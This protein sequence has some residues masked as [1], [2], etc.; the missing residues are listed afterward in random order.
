MFTAYEV[1]GC[2]MS[3]KVNFL[4]SHID[5][6]PENLEAF[7]EEEG[8][9]FHKDAPDIERRYQGKWDVNML[10][11]YCWNAETGNRRWKAKA[12][13]EES[14]REI[15]KVSQTKRVNTQR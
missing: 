13:S 6:F 5:C 1:Q 15:E 12:C 11:D 8:E 3:L 9:I 14:Q 4:H 7:S 10:A 2:K